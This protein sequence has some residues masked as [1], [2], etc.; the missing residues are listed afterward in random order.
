MGS[1]CNSSAL[2]LNNHPYPHGVIAANNM[3]IPQFCQGLTGTAETL[4]LGDPFKT[5][6]L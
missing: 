4:L 6:S 5:R 1:F 2:T 3:F